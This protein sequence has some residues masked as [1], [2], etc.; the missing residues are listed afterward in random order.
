[1]RIE[2]DMCKN[3][4]YEREDTIVRPNRVMAGEQPDYHLC[5]VCAS[6]II[7]IIKKGVIE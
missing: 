3:I 2:C 5:P 4:F 7:N 1:M 6:K